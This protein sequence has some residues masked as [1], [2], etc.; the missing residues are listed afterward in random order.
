M[1]KRPSLA[2]HIFV[3]LLVPII[4]IHLALASAMRHEV[5]QYALELVAFAALGYAQW[6][7][8]RD[9]WLGSLLC[10]GLL[11][12][13]VALSMRAPSDLLAKL[14]Y[15]VGAVLLTTSVLKG[16]SLSSRAAVPAA[17]AM[18]IFGTLFAWLLGLL[19]QTQDVNQRFG[20]QLSSLGTLMWEQAAWPAQAFGDSPSGN[21]RPPIVIVSVDTLRADAATEMKSFRWL[22][23]RGRSWRKA[24]STSSWTLPAVASLQTGLMPVE[25]GAGCLYDSHCQGLADGVPTLAG[26][27]AAHGYDTAA[28]TA[29]PWIS[30]STGVARGYAHFRDFASLMP[31]RLVFGL[32]PRGPH[33]QDAEVLID[34]ALEWIENDR[35][36]G[37]LLWIHLID[38]HMPYLHSDGLESITGR[39]LR[40][41]SSPS[42]QSRAAIRDA[43]AREVA[44]VDGQ[45]L[46]LLETLE[47]R[48]FFAQGT[49]VLTSD[50]GEEFWEHG[51]IEHGHSHHG[52]VV[53][54]PL[55]LVTPGMSPGE[56]EGVASLM[57]VAS[58]LRAIAGI[59]F[60]GLDLREPAP[61]G[62]IALA[63]GTM[64]G[65][66]MRSGRDEL[67]R[68]IAIGDPNLEPVRL[69][70]YDLLA[71]PSEQAALG[72][73][74]D[75][76]LVRSVLDLEG[77][78][79]G[80]SVEPNA[81]ALRALGY[82]E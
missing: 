60:T 27:L 75:G 73:P 56:G 51:G 70:V 35:D 65:P 14:I 54:V 28:F 34:A 20:N 67:H 18:A 4:E 30:N 15:M 53:D 61:R 12:L 71:D 21:G 50:H 46:R 22:A 37:F 80:E 59:P 17:V 57:D 68:A 47:D 72:A 62:R 74:G 40:L 32:R 1:Q 77:P 69:Q 48:R 38:P 36:G 52:E 63:H 26:D 10:P 31:F 5:W 76:F 8:A 44:H 42:A 49:L 81:E 64:V 24:M 19:Q 16:R 2:A 41:G 58:T 33:P 55:V 82:V 6:R 43:Y 39:Q 25:H 3:W 66:L 13:L 79:P 29:N 11:V 45:I 9:H 78:R 23:T 7:W